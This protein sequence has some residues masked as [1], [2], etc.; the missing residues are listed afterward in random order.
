MKV[1][2]CA[3]YSSKISATR[4]SLTSSASAENFNR[5]STPR[6]EPAPG[7]GSLRPPC[8]LSAVTNVLC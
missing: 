5:A 7:I 4:R 2:I 8:D 3:R 6:G 1:A